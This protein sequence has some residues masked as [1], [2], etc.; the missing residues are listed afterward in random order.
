[1]RSRYEVLWQSLGRDAPER[2]RL[3]IVGLACEVA[4]L[5]AL[6]NNDLAPFSRHPLAK[7]FKLAGGEHR[8]VALDLLSTDTRF[9]AFTRE[10]LETVAESFAQRVQDVRFLRGRVSSFLLARRAPALSL[11]E[12]AAA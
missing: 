3:R 11:S 10:D 5:T 8:R 1:M 4:V 7:E 6:M 2:T 9:D 12:F